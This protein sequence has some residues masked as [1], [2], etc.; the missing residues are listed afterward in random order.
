MRLFLSPVCLLIVLVPW[1]VDSLYAAPLSNAPLSNG[2]T[3]NSLATGG[4]LGVIGDSISTAMDADDNCTN[5]WDCL[6]N[7][8]KE[9][10]G[11]SFSKGTQTWSIYRRLQADGY[12]TGVVSA[13][14]N[15]AS[16]DDAFMQAQAIT[17]D[18]DVTTVVI[19]LGGNDVCRKQGEAMPPIS[20]MEGYIDDTLTYLTDH[21]P[22]GG[23]VIVGETP[24]VVDLYE[25][26]RNEPNF[27]FAS[28][29]DIWDLNYNNLNPDAVHD[30]CEQLFGSF[31]CQ[32][33]DV[34]NQTEDWIADLLELTFSEVFDGTFP[35]GK[36]L[37]SASTP[38][39]RAE[40]EAFNVDLNTAIRNKAVSYNGRN[41]VTVVS[42]DD[43]YEYAFSTNEIS[44]LDCFHPSRAGQTA[45]ADVFWPT[46]D[47]ALLDSDGDG[48]VDRGDNC[49][50]V[51]NG[52][53]IPDAGGFS[54][55]DTDGDGFGNVCDADINNDCIVNATDLASMKINFFSS[56]SNTDLNGDGF[57]NASDLGI[58]K[59]MYF[60]PPGSSGLASCP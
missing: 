48:V 2:S 3:N 53:T 50:L 59:A 54:Q 23:L 20:T 1:W 7:H 10:G 22:A 12:V 19:E 32:L 38:E 39:D 9:D 37:N 16:W 25:L 47:N 49:V 24:H 4:K 26:K 18:P 11:Y 60:G 36:V 17:A 41:G 56:E 28:C 27:L 44:Y 55:R 29:Q 46:V 34:I 51:A 40:A 42:V 52:P 45:L 15:G 58:L 57:V 14:E 5:A 31:L 33:S 6:T 8:I 30:V 35:C 21:L 13:A 43:V